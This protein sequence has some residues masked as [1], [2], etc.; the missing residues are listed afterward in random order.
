[1]FVSGDKTFE[2][3]YSSYK[4]Y[5]ETQHVEGYWTDKVLDHVN[6][7]MEDVVQSITQDVKY[8]VSSQEQQVRIVLTWIGIK[9]LQD[10]YGNFRNEWR[11]I[12][13]KGKQFIAGNGL[14]FEDLSF[15]AI[16]LSH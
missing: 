2:C 7:T 15:P 12:V 10:K 1:M 11:L 13:A 16:T 9:M 4:D 3:T 5:T 14:R 8:K 6:L